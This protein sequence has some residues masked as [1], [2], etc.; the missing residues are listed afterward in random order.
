MTFAIRNAVGVRCPSRTG[1]LKHG[2][3]QEWP[4]GQLG[5]RLV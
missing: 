3:S 4:S 5:A 2:D 1:H